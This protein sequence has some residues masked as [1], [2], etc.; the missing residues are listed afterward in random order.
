MQAGSIVAVVG[1]FILPL[2]SPTAWAT[3]NSCERLLSE[4]ELDI[5]RD[6]ARRMQAPAPVAS[7]S[8]PAL[9]AAGLES[10][11]AA[12]PL[13]LHGIDPIQWTATAPPKVRDTMVRWDQWIRFMDRLTSG[14]TRFGRGDD[15]AQIF[16]NIHADSKRLT[17]MARSDNVSGARDI[18][19]RVATPLEIA[20]WEKLRAA[21]TLERL[22][23]TPEAPEYQSSA[24]ALYRANITI[25]RN[26]HAYSLHRRTVE[27]LPEAQKN[28]ILTAPMKD[29]YAQRPD[30]VQYARP[31]MDRFEAWDIYRMHVVGQPNVAPFARQAQILRSELMDT[32]V[33][34]ALYGVELIGAK[35][36]V[37]WIARRVPIHTPVLGKV[38]IGI[39]DYAA[40]HNHLGDVLRLVGPGQSLTAAKLYEGLANINTEHGRGGLITYFRLRFTKNSHERLLSYAAKKSATDN[41]AKELVGAHA[42]AKEMPDLGVT[43]LPISFKRIIGFTVAAALTSFAWNQIEGGR[44]VGDAYDRA[45]QEVR[46]ILYPADGEQPAPAGE[47]IVPGAGVN[48]VGSISASAPEYPTLAEIRLAIDTFAYAMQVTAYEAAAGDAQ[49][50]R[51]LEAIANIRRGFGVRESGDWPL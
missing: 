39:Q 48:L 23:S 4:D 2:T 10:S 32:F 27:A 20:L 3:G 25:G 34:G 37:Q 9:A 8:V 36:L 26:I 33:G 11:P 28:A 29:I 49:A 31:S 30:L 5:A 18:Y 16:N 43:T 35:G 15:T 13:T 51:D 6:I 7:R 1:L 22:Q 12:P 44:M 17:I 14:L 40:I 42:T 50:I 21:E 45:K 46:E 47:G 38:A 41:F 24:K 19:A